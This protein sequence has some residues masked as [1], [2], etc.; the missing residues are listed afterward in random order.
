MKNSDCDDG[1]SNST[2]A[3]EDGDCDGTVTALDCDDGDPAS[4]V[5]ATD[6]DCDG[7]FDG[8]PEACNP[9]N[10]DDGCGGYYYLDACEIPNLRELGRKG[11]LKMGRCL[12]PS[13]TNVDKVSIATAS[14]APIPQSTN[15][16]YP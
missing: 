16:K 6:G 8:P 1:D 12:M 11:F 9:C 5:L 10:G 3:A 4:T 7:I 13:V 2:I 14:Y 15:A